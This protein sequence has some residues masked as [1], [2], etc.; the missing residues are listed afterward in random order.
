MKALLGKEIRGKRPQDSVELAALILDEAEVAVVPGEAF[1]TPGY[2]R[3]SYALGDEDLV[4][5]V[6]PDPEAAG[7]R[8]R[9]DV[10]TPSGR[11]CVVALHARVRARATRFRWAG[12]VSSF[13]QAPRTGKAATGTAPRVRQDPGME[14]VRDVLCCPRPICTCTSPGRCGPRTLLELADKYGVRLPDALTG[15]EPPKLRATDER[16]WFR[17]QRL[18]DIARSCLQRARGHPAAGARG[19]RGGRRGR[20]GLAGDPG[21]P[22]LVRAAAR[23]ADPGHGDHPGRGGHAPPGTPGSGCGSWSPRTG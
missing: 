8:P 10:R 12:L 1:G 21:R 14:H 7:A 11:R 3:L 9:T 2:L 15:G 23:R 16:G 17:F 19:R 20:L 13:G 6:S 22:D 18:Y 5:G 4:E